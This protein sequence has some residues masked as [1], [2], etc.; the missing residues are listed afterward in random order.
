MEIFKVRYPQRSEQGYGNRPEQVN[1]PGAGGHEEPLSYQPEGGRERDELVS[2]AG[3]AALGAAIFRAT[4][5]QGRE[6]ADT[7]A[8]LPSC[9]P[10]SSAA[11][12]PHPFR[13]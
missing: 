2:K 4:T 6:G 3:S 5:E 7:P 12:G 1:L 11:H 13:S 8:S 10:T 9:A